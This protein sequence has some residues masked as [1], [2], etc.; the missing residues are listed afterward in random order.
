VADHG[1]VAL[2]LAEDEERDTR[3]KENFM[4]T[5]LCTEE[6]VGGPNGGQ[7]VS[8]IARYG[9]VVADNPGEFMLIDKKDLN[10]DHSYQRE[11]IVVNKVRQIA[12]HWSWAGCG[13]I[14]VAMR[15]DGSF[16]VFDGQHRVLAAKTRADILQLPCMVFECVDV[17]QEAAGFLVSNAERKPVGALDKFKALVMT[18]D[19]A[20][21]IVSNVFDR[22]D[23]TVATKP[24]HARQLKCVSKCL[25]LAERNA[26]VF[27]WALQSTIAVCGNH[28]VHRDILDGLFWIET[29]YGLCGTDRFDEALAKADRADILASIAKFAAA[30]GKRGERVCGTGILKVLNYKRRNRF[31][32][33]EDTSSD[34]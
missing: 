8:K 10:V 22:L 4:G 25:V 21:E 27:A 13:C 32:I 31:G 28:P 20:A 1:G 29:K 15:L 5:A 9:W 16:W 17:K 2:T 14:L 30:E 7:R 34:D 33:E 3:A 6:T 24:D 26:E 23:I 12:S 19:S 18:G 11:K